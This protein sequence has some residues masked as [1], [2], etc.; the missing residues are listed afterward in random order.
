[1]LYGAAT[2]S[3]SVFAENRLDFFLCYAYTLGN[4]FSKSRKNKQYPENTGR[5]AYDN[6]A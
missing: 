3:R 6:E 1:M 5:N 2:S 4:T